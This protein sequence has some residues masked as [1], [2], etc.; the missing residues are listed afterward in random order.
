MD[1]SGTRGRSVRERVGPLVGIVVAIVVFAAA[2]GGSGGSTTADTLRGELTRPTPAE[3]TEGG[4]LTFGL[5]AETTTGWDPTTSQW[6]TPGTIVSHAIFDRLAAYDENHVA[7][8]YLAESITPNEDNTEWDVKV[9]RGVIFHNGTPLN[10]SA[11]KL[12]LDKQRSGILAGPALSTIESVEVIDEL[13]VRVNVSRPWA[14]FP[15][16]LTSQA[17][18]VAAPEQLESNAPAQNPIGTGP[19][20]FHSWTPDTDFA[21]TRNDSYWQ[22]DSEGRQLPYLQNITFLVLPDPSARGAALTTGQ[23]D[24]IETADPGQML[25]FTAMAEA[26]EYQM[27]TNTD[28]EATVQFVGLNTAKPPFDD[29]LARELAAAAF[30]RNTISRD[31]YQD[32]A[33]PAMGLFPPTSPFFDESAYP[34][35][36]AAKAQQLHDE[37]QAKYGHPLSFTVNLPADPY[38]RAVGEAAQEAA[39]QFGIEMDLN[40][41]DVSALI[42]DALTGNYEATGFQTF[43]DP[44]IDQIF[45]SGETVKPLGEIALNFTR[46]NN[47]TITEALYAARATTDVEQQAEQWKIIQQELAKDLPLLFVVRA[48]GAIIYTNEVFGLLTPPLPTGQPSELTMAVYTHYAFKTG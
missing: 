28:R 27:F 31:L 40:L 16:A 41:L 12:N 37:Y 9:R 14:T 5:S 38:Y 19:F 2:C 32:V 23:V 46:N 17:G 22:K 34:P 6:F 48:R 10:A 20:V 1:R 29:P 42:I 21:A 11:V 8:P 47:P 43:G 39:R 3:P 7:Q 13:T 33:P 30:D 35:F 24:A 4:G 18:V 25:E 45:I 36:D 44:N 26:G 15:A